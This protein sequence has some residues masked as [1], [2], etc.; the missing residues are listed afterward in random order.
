VLGRRVPIGLRVFLTALAILDDLGAIAV[1]AL[2]YT[3][4]LNLPALA[5]GLVVLGG[6]YAMGRAGVRA[7]S[8]FVLG[9][10]L[11]WVCLFQGGVHP[12]LAGVGLAFVIPLGEGDAGPAHR[13]ET[14]LAGW[15]TWCVLPVFGL[16][17]SGLRLDGIAPSALATPLTAGIVLGLVLGKQIGVY[18]A[19]LLGLRLGL[20]RLPPG[21]T[22]R[23]LYGGAI[24]CGIGFTMSLFIG[25]LGFHGT[26][27]HDQ[28]KLAVFAASL[29]SAVLG[30]AV[31]AF[32]PARPAVT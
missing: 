5:A 4:A 29:L 17:N 1:I 23:Q 15:I 16:A 12:T 2:F 8:P 13:L 22:R 11:L 18:G 7:L 6:L 24:L 30:I 14:G 10:A 28:V 19:T 21:L 25:D 31:L 20:A 32:A 9:G 27:L 3:A 26:P